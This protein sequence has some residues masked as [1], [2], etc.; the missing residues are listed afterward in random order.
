MLTFTF[1][2]IEAVGYGLKCWVIT[3]IEREVE[4]QESLLW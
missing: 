1:L 4:K 2:D 3:W